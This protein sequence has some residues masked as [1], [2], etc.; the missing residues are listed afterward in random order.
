MEAKVRSKAIT[1]LKCKKN[2]KSELDDKGVPY[3][4]LCPVCRKKRATGVFF[5][6]IY[7]N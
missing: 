1:C 3:N 7:V 4:K 5:S 6:N 2:F